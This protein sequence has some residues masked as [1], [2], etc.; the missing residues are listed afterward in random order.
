MT[1]QY[2]RT[3]TPNLYRVPNNAACKIDTANNEYVPSVKKYILSAD[4]VIG[5]NNSYNNMVTFKKPLDYIGYNQLYNDHKSVNYV[6]YAGKTLADS[7]SNLNTISCSGNLIL[8]VIVVAKGTY[9]SLL[10]PK[11][12]S[13]A[14]LYTISYPMQPS[15]QTP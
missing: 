5:V 6:G 7:L 11:P 13:Q 4:D 14:Q 2:I 3:S 12:H 10:P 1:E 8:F 15:K 9:A